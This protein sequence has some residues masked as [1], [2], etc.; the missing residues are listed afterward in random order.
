[1]AQYHITTTARRTLI[2]VALALMMH[3]AA[4]A[5]TGLSVNEVFTRY[6]HA[7]GCK[8]VSMRNATLKGYKLNI[9]K[10]LVYKHLADDVAPYLQADRKRARKIREVVEDGLVT[11]GYYMMQPTAEGLNRYIL[12]SN[13][14]GQRGTVIYIEGR[15]SPDDIMTLCYSRRK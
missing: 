13:G 15:L 14:A 3:L 10:S 2:A 12:F 1:M 11:G 8:M 9:Y 4:I 6:G 5:Q 7:K